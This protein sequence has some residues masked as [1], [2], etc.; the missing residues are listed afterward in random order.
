MDRMD[1]VTATFRTPVKTSM[2]WIAASLLFVL[3]SWLI[4]QGIWIHVKA[5]VAQG[6][7]QHAWAQTLITQQET[8][9]WPWAD[10]WPVGQLLVP[11]LGIN[12]IILADASGRS[13]AFGP[14]LVGYETFPDGES[15]DLIV[16]GH[17]DTHFSFLQDLQRG[18]TMIVQTIQ[19]AWFTYV[20]KDTAVVDSRTTRLIRHQ[21]EANVLLITCYPFDAILPGGPLRYVVTASPVSTKALTRRFRQWLVAR[22]EAEA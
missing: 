9:P 2:V 22:Q 18:D 12:Q 6:L 1:L 11:R 8:K 3:G 21:E 4:S 5:T 19:G 16:S 7:L 10:T 15:Q 20:V 17:R 13:L 14:G